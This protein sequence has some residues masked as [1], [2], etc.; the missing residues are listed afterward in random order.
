MDPTGPADDDLGPR[1]RDGLRSLARAA[2]DPS[3]LPDAPAT[4]I[5]HPAPAARRILA[6]AAVIVVVA[7][8]A[9]IALVATD[10]G[11]QQLQAGEPTTTGPTGAPVNDRNTPPPSDEGKL[12]CPPALL[13]L[14]GI[15]ATPELVPPGDGDQP[16]GPT[17]WPY[18][19]RWEQDAYR[20]ELS[21]PQATRVA[22]MIARTPT[23][24]TLADG[25]IADVYP[26][27]TPEVHVHPP[28]L[29]VDP[30]GCTSYW[31]RMVPEEE[32]DGASV[33]LQRTPVE[34]TLLAIAETVRITTPPGSVRVPN[35]TGMSVVDSRDVLARAGLL[36][37]EPWDGRDDGRTVTGQTPAAATEAA[38]GTEVALSFSQPTTTTQP[39]PPPVVPVD[40]LPIPTAPLVCPISRLE[41]DGDFR[42]QPAI[43]HDTTIEWQEPGDFGG[44]TVMLSWPNE[45]YQ[46]DENHG[47]RELTVQGRPALMHDGGDG[48]NLVY[49]TGLPGACRFLQVGVYGGQLAQ[50]EP[51]AEALAGTK[52][53]IAPPPTTAPPTVTGLTVAAA[54]DQLARAGF[55]P[56]WGED[57]ALGDPPAEIPTA[58]VTSQAVTEPGVVRLMT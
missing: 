56:D 24:V 32:D 33:R 40:A 28:D 26:E 16:F 48:Q 50:R 55:I 36:T 35:V 10:D 39:P 34:D 37:T 9:G 12:N 30:I 47:A 41:V 31:L 27:P 17:P 23:P 44:T 43:H 46:D 2:G 7:L 18:V 20:V 52:I 29:E 25:R 53:T 58:V 21:Y 15:E 6:A 51:R 14:S 11:G 38:Y 4:P 22:T 13:D 57:R 54:A 49:D 42:S 19:V 8:A 3:P 5:R 1:L 45:E